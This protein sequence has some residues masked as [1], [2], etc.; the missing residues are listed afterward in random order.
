MV[1]SD[2]W[3]DPNVENFSQAISLRHYQEIGVSPRHPATLLSKSVWQVVAFDYFIV[4]DRDGI[5][6][7]TGWPPGCFFPSK[8]FASRLM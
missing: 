2:L 6:G 7:V 4:T 3:P 8:H 1:H 5:A